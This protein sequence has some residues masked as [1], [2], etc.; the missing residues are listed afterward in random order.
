MFRVVLS[1]VLL[2]AAGTYHMAAPSKAQ[3]Q[4][5]TPLQQK[6]VNLASS[7]VGQSSGVSYEVS[8]W[9]TTTPWF[10]DVYGGD[11][12]RMRFAINDYKNFYWAAP[13]NKNLAPP[14][15]VV[16]LMK[17]R[18][19]GSAYNATSQ[20]LFVQQI[21]SRYKLYSA[22][23]PFVCV[24]PPTTNQA[25]L[26]FLDLRPQCLEFAASVGL[27]CGGKARNY[28]STGLPAAQHRPGMMLTQFVGGGQHA[29]I[30]LAI[31]WGNGVPISYRVAESNWGTG[32]SNPA[33]AI[34]WQRTIAGNRW[35]PAAN[36]WKVISF[37]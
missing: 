17:S 5:L 23:N 12:A 27:A 21:V 33:G 24:Q 3:A 4:N 9:G 32:W 6:V 10:T 28:G 20:D 13:L 25:T 8:P 15:A 30:I 22:N 18:F 1:A 7:R 16:T 19:A 35:V 2:F 11:G 37:E 34:P 26:N 14:P 29:T 31:S 36:V